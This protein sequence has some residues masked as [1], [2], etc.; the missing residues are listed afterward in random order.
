MIQRRREK[1]Q[2]TTRPDLGRL[3]QEVDLKTDSAFDDREDGSGF[4]SA[5]F[6]VRIN[7]YFEVCWMC[8][9][10]LAAWTGPSMRF[11]RLSRQIY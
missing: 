10:P 2:P 11:G 1:E 8:K 9:E 4:L 6:Y 5:V 3:W 7:R